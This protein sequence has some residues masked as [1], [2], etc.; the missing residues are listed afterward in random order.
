MFIV[1]LLLFSVAYLGEGSGSVDQVA[2]IKHACNQKNPCQ[3]KVS[4]SYKSWDYVVI[5]NTSWTFHVDI[6]N[7]KGKVR[8][9]PDPDSFFKGCCGGNNCEANSV[10]S[11]NYGGGCNSTTG[12]GGFL[13]MWNSDFTA[14]ET[15]VI[16]VNGGEGPGPV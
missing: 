8:Y 9:G 5:P 7:G 11:W 6:K 12:T 3:V 14:S 1:A 4:P 10:K 16:T 2:S 13:G 15:F